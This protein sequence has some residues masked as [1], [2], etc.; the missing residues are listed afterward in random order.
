MKSVAKAIYDFHH[1]SGAADKVLDLKPINRDCLAIDQT[2]AEWG[3]QA[4]AKIR[5]IRSKL[6]LTNPNHERISQDLNLLEVTT[7]MT[8]DYLSR[9]SEV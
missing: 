2:I 3:A 8:A 4:E 6:T 7:Y 9:D 5:K 1:T